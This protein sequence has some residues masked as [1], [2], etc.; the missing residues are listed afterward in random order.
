M[1][2]I[3]KALGF[4]GGGAAGYVGVGLGVLS[5][6]MLL[7][8]LWAM[9]RGDDAIE[10]N[11][12]LEGAVADRD[13][14]IRQQ[15]ETIEGWA[16]RYQDRE[17]RIAEEKKLLRDGFAAER[18]IADKAAR[19]A[20]QLKEIFHENPVARAWADTDLPAAVLECLQQRQG[21]CA[22]RAKTPSTDH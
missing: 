22:A 12:R 11:G 15:G 5:A 10:S 13:G 1:G 2:W 17:I 4:F 3:M 6:G 14:V 9:D 20:A 16:Q 19:Q 7:A 18:A 8:F 21:D